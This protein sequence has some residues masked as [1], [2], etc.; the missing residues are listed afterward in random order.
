LT[1]SSASGNQWFLNGNPIGGASGQA[2]IAA[3]SG[4][5]TVKTTDGNSC[6]SAASTIATVTANAIPATPTITP[7]GSAQ[8]CNA[9]SATLTSSSASGNQW[10]LEGTA[11][12]GATNATVS[13]GSAGHYTVIVTTNGCSSAS[14]AATNVTINPPPAKPVVTAGGPTTFCAGGSVTLS[15]NNASGNQWYLDGSPISGG[16]NQTFAA[17]AA[18]SYTA[19]VT[20]AGCVSNAS[21]PAVVTLNPLPATPAVTAGGPTTFC[22]GGSVTLTSSNASGN[23]WFL[24]GNAIG[25]ATNQVYSV[26]GSGSYTVKVTGANACTSAASSATA[27]TVSPIPATPAI[28]PGGPT[29]FCSGGSVNLT[30]S[31]ASGNQWFVNGNAIGGATNQVYGAAASGNY[32]VIVTTTGCASSAPPATTVTVKPKPNATITAPLSVITSSA[33][34]LA[35]VA[36]AGAGATYVWDITGG[37]ITAGS[38]TNSITFTAGGPGTMTITVTVAASSGCSDARSANVTVALP[39][40]TVTSVTPGVGVITGGSPITISGTGFVSGATISA[41]GSAATNV[42]VVS[43]IKITARTPAHAAGTVNVTVT[44]ADTSSGVLTSG[45]R[46]QATVFDPNGDTVIDP[47]D[48]FFLINYLFTG[49]LA[50]HGE[51]GLLSGDANN[52]GAIDPAD[53]FFTINYL[54][55]G[56]PNTP[57]AVPNPPRAM[58]AG[59][60]TPQIAGAISLGNPV[61][62][63]GHNFVPVILTAG[64]GSIVPQTMSLRV[65]IEAEGAVGEAAVRRAGVARDLDTVFEF[66]HRT[67]NDLSYLVSYDPRGLALGATRSAVVAEIEIESADAGVSISIDPL[68]TMLGDQTGRTMATVANGKLRV[69]GISIRRGKSPRPRAPRLELY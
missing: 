14:S 57:A 31:S 9:G 23:Q 26:T 68:L 44:N 53:I 65:H 5:Y 10:Y 4:N 41:G 1:S 63:G 19:T 43:A 37:A 47:A 12:P 59:T 24:N 33:G 6:T 27:V 35:S 11:I 29:T 7:S 64:A 13:A 2:Y 62:R 52:D 16:T 38:G 18:G 30:S 17:T 15:S 58:A 66:S 55:L 25:G 40:V 32:T 3:A 39:P 22:V 20:T 56:G 67:G 50:P 36:S 49:G 28:T 51:A 61:L 45:F 42:V 48:I 54:F 46:Y 60:G 21:D 8:F 34:N 69:S